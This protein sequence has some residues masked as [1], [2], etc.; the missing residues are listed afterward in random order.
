MWR[1]NNSN[2]NIN[3]SLKR[4]KGST[5]KITFF[6]NS[7]IKKKRFEKI[8][9][10]TK[11]NNKNVRLKKKKSENVVGLISGPIL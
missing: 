3:K 11:I 1:E 7:K 8:I 5:L 9:T 6:N 10:K 2:T 4:K